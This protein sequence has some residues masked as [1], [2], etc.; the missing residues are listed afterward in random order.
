MF[1]GYKKLRLMLFFPLLISSGISR[2]DNLSSSQVLGEHINADCPSVNECSMN[3]SDIEPNLA[4]VCEGLKAELAWNR[5]K[6][7]VF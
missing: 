2:G 6:P 1:V 7:N 5:K 3:V 4:G